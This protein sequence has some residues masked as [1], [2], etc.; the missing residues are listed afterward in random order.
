F[1]WASILNMGPSYGQIVTA[2][3]SG[4]V[5]DPAGAVIPET[6]VTVTNTHTGISARTVSD[7]SGNYI[8]PAL[9]PGDYTISVEKSGFKSTVI[10]GITL[11]V[12]QQVRVDARLQVGAL[13]TTVEVSGAAPLVQTATASV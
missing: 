10:S 6:R 13:A 7:S 2:S 1:A 12:N 3:L 5:T 4:S 9:S 11:L 8:F